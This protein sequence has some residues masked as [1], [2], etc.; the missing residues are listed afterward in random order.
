M[1]LRIA[2]LPLAKPTFDLGLAE[3]NLAALRQHLELAG[4]LVAGGDR[5]LTGLEEMQAVISCLKGEPLDL[6]L[7]FQAAFTD[8]TLVCEL[9]ASLDVPLFLS[10]VPEESS[11][12]RLRL[13]SL[14]GL[15]LAAHAL[16][17]RKHPYEYIYAKPAEAVALQKLDAAARAGRVYRKLKTAHL[18]IAGEPPAGMDSCFLEA[19]ELNARL[20]ITV[21]SLPLSLV[22]ERMGHVSSAEAA[23]VQQRLAGRLDGLE[24]VEQAPLQGSLKA[25]RA[26]DSLAGELGLD[27]LAVRCWPEFFTQ[28]GCAACGALSLLSEGGIPASCEADANGA[29][30]QLILQWL[31]GAPAFGTDIVSADFAAGSLVVWH[32]GQAPL[33]LADPKFRPRAAVHS[34]RRLPLLMEF[35]LKPGRVTLA[36]LSRAGGELRLVIGK[37]TMLS[38]P[39]SFSG[40]SGVLQP[41]SPAEQV[42]NTLLG[43]GLEHHI[44]LAYG[45]HTAS[46][47]FLAKLL[48]LP[49]LE[50]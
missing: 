42:L 50:L 46:L 43:Q 44:A 37:G 4:F 1:E 45:D 38:A 16:T 29:V 24:T 6:L 35:P 8:S 9:A 41:D 31:S 22:F 33:S 49:V 25:Y 2:L 11:G 12:G 20:G 39:L 5:L 13:N 3:E 34:N 32:C 14:C 28:M 10:A 21:H 48:R 26:L 27:A 40:T 30:S 36:R 15:N 19:G 47:Q 18:G 7:V 17:L 23:A